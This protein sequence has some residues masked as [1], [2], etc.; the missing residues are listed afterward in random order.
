MEG[1]R[2]DAGSVTETERRTSAEIPRRAANRSIALGK[3]LRKM[4]EDAAARARSEFE[5]AA[6]RDQSGFAR[7][8][9]A[10]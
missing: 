5:E 4:E 3:L 8:L 7:S 2:A 10:G 1:A 9:L 6:V